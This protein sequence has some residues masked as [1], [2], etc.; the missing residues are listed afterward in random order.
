MCETEEPAILP[1]H[2]PRLNP[3][4]GGSESRDEQ[5]EW[6]SVA[7][8]P[9]VTG[10]VDTREEV[11]LDLRLVVVEVGVVRDSCVTVTAPTRAALVKRWTI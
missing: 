6:V 7:Q 2:A 5:L 9:A 11:E 8:A 3:M 10:A 1:T 4:T